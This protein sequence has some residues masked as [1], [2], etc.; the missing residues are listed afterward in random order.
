MLTEFL[1]TGNYEAGHLG[2]IPRICW[3]LREFPAIRNSLDLP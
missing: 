2:S 1:K 3:P